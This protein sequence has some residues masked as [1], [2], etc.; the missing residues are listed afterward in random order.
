MTP[1]N[2]ELEAQALSTAIHEFQQANQDIQTY[3][4]VYGVAFPPLYRELRQWLGQDIS[5][6]RLSLIFDAQSEDGRSQYGPYL[7]RIARGAEKPSKLLTRLA[8]A[9]V[10][11]YRGVSF[12]FSRLPTDD[13]ICG[14]SERLDALCEDGSEWQMKFFDTRSLAVLD[15][16][17][18]AEQ[19]RAYLG[20]AK[21]WWYLDRY[22]E[23]QKLILADETEDSYC[24]PLRLSEQQTEVFVDAS[25][26][27]SVLHSLQLSDDD[28]LAEFDAQTRY[29][30]CEG[31]VA[32]ATTEELLSH[33]LL[34]NR[35]GSALLAAHKQ[36]E[37]E[38]PKSC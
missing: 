2:P 38:E 17:L 22:G 35:V 32:Q 13:L 1:N 10:D 5:N 16:A 25:L 11:D 30:V 18:S 15:R 9:C 4:L 8:H 21:Q 7:V 37:Q 26:P 24:G 34:T 19:R 23:T 6:Q 33:M 27:D 20:L 12:L 28:L 29:R 36:E 14:L 31:I 3:A